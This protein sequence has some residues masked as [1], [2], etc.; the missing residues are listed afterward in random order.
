MDP[1]K[2]VSFDVTANDAT[3]APCDVHVCQDGFHRLHICRPV[4]PVSGPG[5]T[6]SGAAPAL[7]F[8]NTAAILEVGT[9]L[10]G[11]FEILQMLGSSVAWVLS[12]RLM[13]ATSNA[14]LY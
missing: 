8:A 11:R 7:G 3:Y 1:L 9:V 6:A 4:Y 12:T 2:P 10:A 14:S 5:R 13:I